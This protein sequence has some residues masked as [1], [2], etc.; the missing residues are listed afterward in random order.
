MHVHYLNC[1]SFSLSVRDVTHCLLIETSEGL[2][3]VDT[4]LGY[5]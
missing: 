3:L 4:C 1:M 5:C 2:V